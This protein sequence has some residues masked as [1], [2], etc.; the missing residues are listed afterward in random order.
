MEKN[1]KLLAKNQTI[2]L[3]SIGHIQTSASEMAFHYSSAFQECSFS[4]FVA[5]S[6]PCSVT[7]SRLILK[8]ICNVNKPLELR[9]FDSQCLLICICLHCASYYD[10]AHS[11]KSS[12]LGLDTGS[13]LVTN[14]KCFR[15]KWL[16]KL[17]T[18]QWGP[19]L[20]LIA[21]TD[22]SEFIISK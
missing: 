1:A 6:T 4:V 2:S 5:N 14:R 21:W 13:H 3:E 19:H 17:Y 7:F 11:H 15:T 9:W 8:F 18:K 16:E 12:A 22:N 10:V 20:W